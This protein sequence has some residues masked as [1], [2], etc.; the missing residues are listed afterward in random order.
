MPMDRSLY[1]DNWDEIA[2]AIKESVNWCCEACGRPC[3]RPDETREA[4]I[5]RLTLSDHWTVPELWEANDPEP[6]ISRLGR[7]KLTVAHLN[8]I[9]G[10]CDLSNL[11]AWCAPCHCRYDLKQM[12][13]KRVLKA[14]RHGQLRL[15]GL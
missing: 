8:H 2:L 11:R 3:R 10:D 12:G 7:F 6:S 13:Q 1:P 15:E 9:P 4:A 5:F 14:E